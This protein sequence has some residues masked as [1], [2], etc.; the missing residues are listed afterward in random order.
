MIATA[1][2]RLGIEFRD[3]LIG[4]VGVV[5]VVV[6]ELL[7]L[8]LAR[9]RDAG[10]RLRPDV[11][12]GALMRV[13]AIAQLAR[14]LAAERAPFRR[15]LA[16]LAREP[17]G[18]RRVIGGR[19]GVGL[20]RHLAAEAQPRRSVMGSQLI[21]QARII[22]DIDDHDDVGV[23]F[24]RGANHRGAA[25]VDVLHHFVERRGA[26]QRVLERIEID[27]Q[28]IDRARCCARAWPPDAR[29]RSEP[30]AARR[31]RAD[32]ASSAARPSFPEIR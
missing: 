27:H 21:E 25:D 8:D 1:A 19:A 5:D 29:G 30:R 20:L 22:L 23:I 26:A 14:E 31:G 24:R 16:G 2:E 17:I 3:Q 28:Q 13:L 9:R 6:G 18:N 10:A 32:A 4:G 7:A 11:E 15:A 12:G